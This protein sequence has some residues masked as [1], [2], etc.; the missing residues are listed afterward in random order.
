MPKILGVVGNRYYFTAAQI[1][2]FGEILV[3][4]MRIQ[5]VLGGIISGCPKFS[6]Q[7]ITT[8]IKRKHWKSFAKYPQQQTVRIFHIIFIYTRG[9]YPLRMK[10][11]DCSISHFCGAL[12]SNC[13]NPGDFRLELNSTNRERQDHDRELKKQAKQRAIGKC[14][15]AKVS[16]QQ[17]RCKQHAEYPCF[18]R[19]GAQNV[20]PHFDILRFIERNSRNLPKDFDDDDYK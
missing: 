13:G 1:R 17:L 8:P 16:K 11:R 2:S 18:K 5:Y 3:A 15:K 14:K 10:E 4:F 20:G 12:D 19:S 7:C 6:K 9:Y